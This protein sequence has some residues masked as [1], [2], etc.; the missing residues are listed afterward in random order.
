[1]EVERVNSVDLAF[2]ESGTSGDP[3]VLVHGSWLDHRVWD[4]VAPRLAES[5]RVLQYDRRGYGRSGR[6]TDP[7]DLGQDVDDLAG[8]LEARG[9][10]PAHVVGAS[11]GG[12]VALRLAVARPELVRGVAV[13]EPPLFGLLDPRS[14]EVTVLRRASAD[15]AERF[16]TE[17]P[18]AAARRFAEI[19]A[20]APGGWERLPPPIREVVAEHA[21]RWLAEYRAPGTFDIDPEALRSFDP[22]VLLT[23]GSLAPVAFARIA[24]L[25]AALL[26]NAVRRTLDGVGHMPQLTAPGVYSSAIFDFCLERNVPNW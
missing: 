7:Y 24:D 10:Y 18:T 21:D 2:D 4:A 1:M 17:G 20:G 22:P 19:L 5:F 14:A 16:A 3:I 13:H 15:V 12:S 23:N 25:L 11:L 6:P 26:P 8:L 9:H